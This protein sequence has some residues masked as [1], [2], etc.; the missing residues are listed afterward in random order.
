MSCSTSSTSSTS[1]KTDLGF[2][3]TLKKLSTQIL[4]VEEAF[5]DL[6]PYLTKYFPTKDLYFKNKPFK[7]FASRIILESFPLDEQQTMKKA[8]K[9]HR[10]IRRSTE[11]KNL[12]I[13]AR[14]ITAK[15][16]RIF[17]KIGIMQWG[18]QFTISAPESTGENTR[19]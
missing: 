17:N 19:S 9:L 12:R 15:I 3:A 10:K 14:N 8:N 4:V 16:N 6:S 18:E 13:S 7:Q 11:T 1:Y 5:N 2:I